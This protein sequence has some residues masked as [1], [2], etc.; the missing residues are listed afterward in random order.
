M[1]KNK[2]DNLIHKARPCKL[3]H[4]SFVD[5][6]CPNGAHSFQSL[7]HAAGWLGQEI[8]RDAHGR[9][10]GIDYKV[11][12]FLLKNKIILQSED[13]DYPLNGLRVKDGFTYKKK[14]Q[15]TNELNNQLNK[16]QINQ[17][18]NKSNDQEIN[19]LINSQEEGSSKLRE[20]D[21]LSLEDEASKLRK[22]DNKRTSLLDSKKN[23]W[24]LD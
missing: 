6:D 10:D 3:I 14:D 9:T 1:A 20:D 18:I 2:N 16:E 19:K 5:E 23:V 22:T 11:L 8:L 13:P 15:Q 24:L 7:S 17:E 4:P 21:H 12:S